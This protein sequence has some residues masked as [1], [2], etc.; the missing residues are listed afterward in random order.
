MSTQ[1]QSLF[2]EIPGV[3]QLLATPLM[4]RALTSHPR[5]LVL[6][7]IHQVLE[8]IR[9]KIKSGA[10]AGPEPELQL[11]TVSESVSERLAALSKPS[12]REV[13]N[14]TGVVVHTNLGRSILPETAL[15]RLRAI[16][17]GYSNLEYALDQG[18]RGSRYVHVEGI[19]QELT[20]AESAMVVNNN[21][22]AVLIAIETLARGR[23]AV[24]SRGQLVEIGGSF[25]IPDVMR[26]SGARMIEV[27]TTN[28]THPKDYEEVIGPETALLLKVHTSNF[29]VVGFTQEVPME[30]LADLG[31]RHGIPVMEDLGSGCLMDF[32]R[33][34]MIQ[35]P[36]V[37]EVLAQGADLVTFSGDKLLGGPQAGIILGREGLMEAIRKNPLNR[38]LRIDKLTLAALEETLRLYRDPASVMAH[39]PTL[40]MISQSYESLRKK[41]NRLYARLKG[42]RTDN[43]TVQRADGNSKVGGGALPLQELPTRLLCLIPRKLSAQTIENRLRTHSPPVIARVEKDRVMLDVRTI[44]TQEFNTVADAIRAVS[45]P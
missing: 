4:E 33:I 24:V 42:I 32:A 40:R 21:A 25:R 6:N 12:L 10:I 14:A 9:G 1:K 35:E 39:I 13:V 41:A 11:E 17:G 27:G 15:N 34:G 38:A 5:G 18:K 36:T 3:D 23:E 37:Q 26:K 19:L 29:Q 44:Q 16:G 20:G 28:K 2:R 8:D 45:F 22:G 31:R 43:F 30:A 7:A